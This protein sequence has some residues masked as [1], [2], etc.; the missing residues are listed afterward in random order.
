MSIP[1]IVIPTFGLS[2]LFEKIQCLSL[3]HEKRSG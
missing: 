3:F 2:R 1:D